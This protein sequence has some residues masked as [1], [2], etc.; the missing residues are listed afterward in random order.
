MSTPHKKERINDVMKNAIIIF[1][2]VLVLITLS[3]K[4]LSTINIDTKTSK[5]TI[6]PTMLAVKVSEILIIGLKISEKHST[7]ILVLPI[8]NKKVK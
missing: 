4:L 3:Y 1:D 5:T 6:T 2:F 7:K 8:K